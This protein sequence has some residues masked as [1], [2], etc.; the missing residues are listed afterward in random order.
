MFA[1]ALRGF[2]RGIQDDTAEEPP[3]KK[4]ETDDTKDLP[5]KEEKME[6]R[7]PPVQ[8]AEEPPVKK[9]KMEGVEP[10][11]KQEEMEKLSIQIW[12]YYSKVLH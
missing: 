12:N 2:K 7:K 1:E 6:S 4:E 9:I 11:V 8:D 3:I 10:P 5:S